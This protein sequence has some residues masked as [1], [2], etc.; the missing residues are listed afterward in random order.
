MSLLNPYFAGSNLQKCNGLD[1]FFDTF[2]STSPHRLDQPNRLRP[3]R[4][5]VVKKEKVVP[6]AALPLVWHVFVKKYTRG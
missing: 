4:S 6:R 5:E 2:L 3:S 1:V